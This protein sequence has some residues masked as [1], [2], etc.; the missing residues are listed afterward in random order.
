MFLFDQAKHKIE[1]TK[2]LAFKLDVDPEFLEI[3]D[4]KRLNNISPENKDISHLFI[5]KAKKVILKTQT[6]GKLDRVMTKNKKVYK[7]DYTRLEV[8]RAVQITS[9]VKIV[10]PTPEIRLPYLGYYKLSNRGI[11]K[12]LWKVPAIGGTGHYKWFSLDERVT[13]VKSSQTQKEIGEVRGL[14]DGETYV[15]VED[16]FNPFNYDTI[17]VLVT[18]VGSLTWFEERIESEKEGT[19]DYSHLIAFDEYGK[20]Y[21]NCSSLIYD[22]TLKK[23]DEGTI[24]IHAGS[25]S[26]N[27]TKSFLKENLELV[28]LKS[29]FDDNLDIIYSSELPENQEFDEDF[30]FHNNFGICGSDMYITQNEGLARVKASLP[31]NYDINKYSSPVETDFIHIASYSSPKTISPNY[32]DIFKDLEFQKDFAQHAKL[33]Q[34]Y[35]T[36]DVFKISYGSRLI[37]IYNGGTNYWTDD[38]YT[39]K[40]QTTDDAD[41]LGIDLLSDNL[42]ALANRI[43]Y[44]FD[45]QQYNQQD[46]KEY[47]VSV[48]MQ[49]KQ[50]RSLLRPQK[51]V[52][53]IK[54]H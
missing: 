34:S 8:P 44:K 53:N 39:L 26:W 50:T 5:I 13:L 33:F 24:R 7:F 29:R 20:K 45:C 4:V 43:T 9:Q 52:A 18:K 12:Q 19:K 14:N 54:V 30:E 40:H 35:Y 1:L 32:S 6:K 16:A 10:H 11:N 17:K 38:I 28:K 42:P 3:Y 27:S 41:G 49:N 23:E 25:L 51:N 48:I 31:I 22:L 47:G 37:W 36:E 46:L 15:R 2:N 21:T